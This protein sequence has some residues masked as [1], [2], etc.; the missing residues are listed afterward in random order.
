M[1][2]AVNCGMIVRETKVLSLTLGFIFVFTKPIFVF[3]C[4]LQNLTEVDKGYQV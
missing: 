4:G 3:H 2:D 1:H